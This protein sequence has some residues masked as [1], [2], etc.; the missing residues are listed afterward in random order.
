MK[1]LS[2]LLL[3]ALC[4]CASVPL[5]SMHTIVDR[6]VH[7]STFR[8]DTLQI[9]NHGPGQLGYEYRT[10]SGTH[11]QGEIGVGVRVEFHK[12]RVQEL[13]LRPLQ[14]ESSEVS[15]HFAAGEGMGL[16]LER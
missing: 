13:W 11:A 9:S 4:G 6:P 14:G 16:Y 2:I 7:V 5:T 12:P 15:L 8:G 3:V 10:A 1:F